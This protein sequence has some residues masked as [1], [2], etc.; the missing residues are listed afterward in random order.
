MGVI[1]CVGCFKI[2]VSS[3]RDCITFGYKGEVIAMRKIGVKFVPGAKYRKMVTSGQVHME[4]SGINR[5]TT[6]S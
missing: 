5:L 6:L 3:P 2:I 4:V 1:A